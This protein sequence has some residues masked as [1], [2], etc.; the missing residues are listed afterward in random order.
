MKKI[1]RVVS[2]AV[3]ILI[4]FFLLFMAKG[5]LHSG[6]RTHKMVFFQ[7]IKDWNEAEFYDCRLD[8]ASEEIIFAKGYRE[9][10]VVTHSIRPGFRFDELLLSWN[11]AK[12]PEDCAINFEVAVSDDEEKWYD[13]Q[14][15]TYGRTDSLEYN[16]LISLPR[17][18]S[19]V[20]LVDTDILRLEKRM[21]FARVTVRAFIFGKAEMVSL[22]RISL[23]FASN[24]ASWNE[25]ILAGSKPFTDEIGHVKL[26]VPYY[27]QR[28]LPKGISGNAC[29]PTSLTMVLN[30]YDRNVD[31]E[32]IC[33]SAYD[34]YHQMYGNWPYNAEAA[35][36]AGLSKTWVE[37][38][39]GFDEV[40]GEVND[41]KPVI[42]SIAYGYDEL[43]NSPIHEAG[44]G[45]L[46]VV[47]GFDGPNVVIC[48]DPAGHGPE[49]GIIRYPRK[50][51][52]AVWIRH[53]GVAYH[54]WP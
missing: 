14:Y 46:I 20:G 13:F 29:S 43:P 36:L 48:N 2:I 52:E 40:Y 53:G 4:S 21:R 32:S 19:H 39:S 6:K 12:L 44:V 11:A 49:D 10:M 35:Y 41:G 17:A 50:E 42:I 9:S 23:C 37:I 38:H 26:A 54:L 7:D 28:N 30:Y 45:H 47:V 18:V 51:L 8:S 22:R 25:Y 3:V 31:L 5:N 16:N 1:L 15:Q 27:S 33:R 24:D 34:P